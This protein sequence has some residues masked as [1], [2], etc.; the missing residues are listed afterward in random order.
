MLPD[1]TIEG[2]RYAI[3]TAIPFRKLTLA[4]LRR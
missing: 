3:R 4:D 2:F 1:N